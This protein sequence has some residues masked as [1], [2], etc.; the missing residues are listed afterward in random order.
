L[1]NHTVLLYLCNLISLTKLFCKEIAKRVQ[2]IRQLFNGGRRNRR[3]GVVV[4]DAEDKS[5]EG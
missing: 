1:P 5:G 3:I 4:E 2:V